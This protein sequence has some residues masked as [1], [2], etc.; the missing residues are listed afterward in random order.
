MQ[1]LCH[2]VNKVYCL[3]TNNLLL[4]KETNMYLVVNKFLKEKC[5]ECIFIIT[6][7][8]LNQITY[9]PAHIVDREEPTKM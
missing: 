9:Y 7:K 3:A 5:E 6:Q 4:Q 2:M 1:Q 8:I